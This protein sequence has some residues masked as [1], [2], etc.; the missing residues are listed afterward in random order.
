MRGR[1]LRHEFG[2]RGSAASLPGRREAMVIAE[3]GLC[4]RGI[5]P[6][7]MLASN[8]DDRRPR[9]PR[10]AVRACGWRA[11]SRGI[12][13]LLGRFVERAAG[14]ARTGRAGARGGARHVRAAG[15]GRTRVRARDAVGAR[16]PD[17]VRLLV[18]D[19]AGVVDP[20]GP[21]VGLPQPRA[22]LPRVRA[23]RARDRRLRAACDRAVGLR[24][25]R[26]RRGR[27]RLGA[28][29]EGCAVVGRLGA[30]RP[31]QLA[32]RVLERARAPAGLR[33]APRALARRAA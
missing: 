29:R 4:K 18:R 11:S 9:A 20:A 8:P 30:D 5:W 7:P 15:S 3:L 26:G 21:D 6:S 12:R 16:P 32:D 13:A 17:G 24:A 23:R 31:A 2:Q 1:A 19:L 10:G 27:A 14:V 33:A 22:R 28:A 25:R